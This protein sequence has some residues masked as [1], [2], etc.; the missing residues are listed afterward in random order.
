M[1]PLRND[2]RRSASFPIVT[3]SIIAINVVVFVLE[4]IEGE[5]FVVRWALAP[6]DIVAGRHWI[7]LLTSMFMHGGWLHIVSNMGF[8]WV[9][10]PAIEEVMLQKEGEQT[11]KTRT[12][13]LLAGT[14]SAG[15]LLTRMIRSRRRER[16]E[17]NKAKAESPRGRLSTLARAVSAAAVLMQAIRTLQQEQEEHNKAE[18][19]SPRGHKRARWHLVWE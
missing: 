1:I 19:E 15:V 5:D 13:F 11:M 8:L 18:V 9:F 10:G 7:T 17:R 14:V 6:A 12:F 2:S 4:S 3:V 16:E